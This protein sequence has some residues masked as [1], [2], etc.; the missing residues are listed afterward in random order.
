MDMNNRISDILSFPGKNQDLVVEGW[1]RTKRDSKSVCFLEVTDGSCL[2]NLQIIIDKEKH[3]LEKE[4]ERISTGTSVIVK[5]V[6]V[7]S[8]GKNQSVELQGEEI[9]ILGESPDDYPLQK[10]LFL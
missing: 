9:E 1:I 5:G 10:K 4:I 3:N 6:L 7:E 2:K 8:P